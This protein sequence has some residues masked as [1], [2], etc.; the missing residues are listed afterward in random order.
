MH[1]EVTC[2]SFM[3]CNEEKRVKK[4]EWDRIIIIIII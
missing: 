4:C 2:W 1:D 3:S